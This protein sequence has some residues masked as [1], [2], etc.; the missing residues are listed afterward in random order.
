MSNKVAASG[1][2]G[3]GG[4]SLSEEKEIHRQIAGCNVTITFKGYN[5]DIKKK[6]LDML[7]DSFE[8]HIMNSSDEVKDNQTAKSA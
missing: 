6:I 2:D 7:C 1:I 4:D 8:E 5:P 3:R